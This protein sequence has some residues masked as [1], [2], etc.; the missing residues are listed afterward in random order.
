M[1]THSAR[2]DAV[3]FRVL[4]FRLH[5]HFKKSSLTGPQFEQDPVPKLTYHDAEKQPWIIDTKRSMLDIPLVYAPLDPL[6]SACSIH[7]FYV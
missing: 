5:T 6:C 3:N 1:K 4:R 7:M 2:L